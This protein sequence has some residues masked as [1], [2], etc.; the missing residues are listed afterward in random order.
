MTTHTVIESLAAYEAVRAADPD[1]S[2]V[3]WTTSPYLLVNLPKQ[4]EDVRSPEAGLP[5]ESFDALARAARDL[6][7]GY[8]AWLQE[9][10]DWAG[11]A[12]FRFILALPLTRC[13]FATAYKALLLT[14]VKEAAGVE[15]AAC[16]GNPTEPGLSGLSLAYGRVDTLFAALAAAW[17]GSGVAAIPH[18]LPA[19]ASSAIDRQVRYRRMGRV[20][21]VLSLLNNTPGSFLFKAWRTL[22]RFRL[23]PLRR[24]SLRPLPGRTFWVLKECELLEEAA[25]G[26]LRRGGRLAQL[27]PLPRPDLAL[28]DPAGLPRAADLARRLEG[29]ARECAAAHGVDWLPGFD[30]ALGLVVRRTLLFLDVLRRNLAGLTAGFEA[31]VQGMRPGD[32]VLTNALTGPV[33]GLFYGFCRSRNIP[34]NAFDHGVTLGLSEWSLS[35]ARQAG[36]LAADRGFYH[37][38]RAVAAVKEHAPEQETHAVGLPR[39]MARPVLR[40]VQR[41]L[42]RWLLGIGQEE[43]VVMFL[44]ELERNNFVYGPQQDNDLQFLD[45]TRAVTAALCRAYPRSRVVLK[46]YPTQRYADA[47]DFADLGEEFPNLLIAGG[48]DFRFLRAASDLIL[49][50]SNQSTLG[51]VSG[52]GAAFVYLDFAWNPGRVDGLRLVLPDIPGLAAAVLPDAGGVCQAAPGDVAAL[53]MSKEN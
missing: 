6:G 8:C 33:E 41:R 34:V 1:G 50:S 35:E 14:R 38:P 42:G 9:E 45:K 46:L 36:M 51:W 11:Y 3:W 4:G 29:M 18:V 31:V 43:R 47:Y 10:C 21:K 26:I 19:E 53:L 40:P 22:R 20:E 15:P 25:L 30:A 2:R 37:C 7:D 13:F 27:R 49:T 32:E 12:G 16:V 24:L 48:V 23:F 39:A 52:S 28:A 5:Q 44:P 17:P